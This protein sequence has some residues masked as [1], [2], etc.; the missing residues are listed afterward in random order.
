MDQ[1]FENPWWLPAARSQAT[2]TPVNRQ[3]S[4]ITNTEHTA[5]TWRRPPT[6]IHVLH[7][8]QTCFLAAGM[9]SQGSRRSLILV[10]CSMAGCNDERNFGCKRMHL[11]GCALHA[12]EPRRLNPLL[13]FPLFPRQVGGIPP[14]KDPL[15][16]ARPFQ[17]VRSPPVFLQ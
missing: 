6:L 2:P 17:H 5:N 4:H 1:Q 10:P 12:K 13:L 3:S 14:E 7:T 11:I 15:R 8:I 16:A 9:C